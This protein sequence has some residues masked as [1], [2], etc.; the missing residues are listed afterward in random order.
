[1][2]FQSVSRDICILSLP[3]N[4]AL[5]WA[6]DLWL[7]SALLILAYYKTVKVLKGLAEFLWCDIFF[8]LCGYVVVNQPTV[9]C[10]GISRG[11]VCGCSRW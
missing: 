10:G 4:H 3:G 7:K 1:M 8:I 9:H 11:R 2:P 5:W 6:G